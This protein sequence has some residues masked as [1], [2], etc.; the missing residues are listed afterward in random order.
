MIHSRFRQGRVSRR[1][2][3]TVFGCRA[4]V[5]GLLVIVVTAQPAR[6]QVRRPGMMRGQQTAL[7]DTAIT[8]DFQDLELGYVL[9]ALAQA[10]GINLI[11]HDLPEKQVTLRT[12]TPVPRA[13]IPRVI[14]A[15]ATANGLAV[16]EDQGFMHLTGDVVD[17]DPRQ[18]YIYRLRHARAAT[19]AA[20]LQSLVS[21]LSTTNS[22]RE[23]A[24][25][26]MA[27][28]QQLRELQAAQAA[29]TQRGQTV[30]ITGGIEAGL[31]MDVLIVPE[32]VTNSLLVRAAPADWEIVEQ[33]IAALDLRPLQVV[34]EVL[35]TEVR[36]SDDLDLGVGFTAERGT[37]GGEGVVDLPNQ[38]AQQD[39]T[40]LFQIGGFGD[41]DIQAS[42][43][44]LATT[45]E[46]RI[47]SRPVIL[48]QNNQ[49]A[50]IIVGSQQP[51]VQSS[52]LLVGDPT[53]TPY[54]TVQYREVGTVLNIL[55]TINEDGY[56][57]MSVTQEVS[58][59]T[60]ETQFGAPVIST[61]E[62]ETQLLAMNGQTVVLGGLVDRQTEKVRSGIPI[63]KDLPLIGWLFRTT[64][65]REGTSE[66]FLFLTPYI[67]A[68]DEDAEAFR[69]RIEEQQETIPPGLR[70]QNLTP[71]VV[72][73]I[74]PDIPFEIPP[75][76]LPDEPARSCREPEPVVRTGGAGR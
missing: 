15:L 46:V 4:A 21:G 45:G 29:A 51:F 47:L 38:P 25:R 14:R 44:A 19:L 20:T 54:Q 34:I 49:E 11:Y 22:E 3:G 64:R 73:H 76:S 31:Q 67:V 5:L 50:R 53:A 57:N 23:I 63:L 35:I 39:D 65:E 8:L 58:S 6:A 18:F 60:E 13:D 68:S 41:V 37:A 26:Y 70:E 1:I 32:E 62:A 42:L 36:R 2:A 69:Q 55:P 10:G 33:A 27:L 75:D 59:A 7:A 52:Q 12:A 48:A 66:L 56:V 16:T 74:P 28:S 9:T 72:T 24:Q 71:P 30:S 40:F 17:P 43:A 61:R